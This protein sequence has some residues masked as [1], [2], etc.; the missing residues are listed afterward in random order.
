MKERPILFGGPMAQAILRGKKTQ[1]R[2]VITPSW[3]RCLDLDDDDDRAAAVEQSPYGAPGDRLWVREAWRLPASADP[4]SGAQ[5]GA[6]AIE[7]GYPR[8]WAPIRYEADG[9][10]FDWPEDATPGR[11]RQ[12]RF[13][14]RWAS[15]LTLEVVDVRVERL[16]AITEEDARAEGVDPYE[17]PSGP[18]FPDARAAFRELWGSI[19]GKRPGC[20]WA[21]DPW[22]WVVAFRRVEVVR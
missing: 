18:A 6:R 13:M 3:A 12:A 19:N 16:T 21:D 4:L 22:V 8:P 9:A 7:A 11:Y 5:A 15:R 14:P 10:R 20:S 2:R 1:T 17:C